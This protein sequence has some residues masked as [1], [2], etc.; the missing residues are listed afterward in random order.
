MF[1][2]IFTGFLQYEGFHHFLG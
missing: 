1:G 2:R